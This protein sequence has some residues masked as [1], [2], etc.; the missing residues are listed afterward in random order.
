MEP[1]MPRKPRLP[2]TSPTRQRG[3]VAIIVGLSLAVMLG[4]IGLAIDGGRLYLTKTELQ[5]AADAC[6]L[7]AA[8][9]LTG[10]PIP[11]EAFVRA[12]AAGKT[13]GTR[14]R[15]DFQ[16]VA[17]PAG[18]ISLSY[19]TALNAGFALAGAG[20][21]KYV[22]C[23]VQRSGIQPYFMQAVGIGNQA[24]NAIATATLAPAQTNCAVPMAMCTRGAAPSYGYSAG[25]WIGMDFSQN[26]ANVNYTGNFRWIDFTPSEPTPGCG[27]SQ[28]APELSCLLSGSGA[29]SLPAPITTN[30]TNGG[31]PN[32]QPSCVGAT[33]AINAIE[34]AYNTRFGVYANGGGYNV[35]NAPPDFTG[36]SYS[37]ENWT[38]GRDAYAGAVGALP[39]YRTARNART[40]IQ[41]ATTTNPALYSNADTIATQPQLEDNGADRRLVVLPIVDCGNFA[42]SQTA[43][44]RAYACVLL[45]DP[46]RRQ[47]NDVASRLE[48]LGR[49]NEPGSPCASSGI[50]GNVTSQGPLV[51]SLVQ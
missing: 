2:A 40:P 42:T 7:A 6:A 20:N 12:E 51:P 37:T 38:L 13:V 24:V 18:D 5:N 49:S 47:G 14:N 31:G 26:G 48:Y 11:A 23:T 25:D 27:N 44:V 30:C 39:N 32:V 33:G 41:A 3:A 46:Y 29:C 9:E 1:S 36:Y 16:N 34:R 17:I 45:L 35:N 19:G 4:F 43:A 28:G 50:A 21:A 8:Y 22:R 15:V 10:V